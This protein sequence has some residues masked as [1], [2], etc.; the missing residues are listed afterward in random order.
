MS[1][2]FTGELSEIKARVQPVEKITH[3]HSAQ[4]RYRQY[5]R[6]SFIFIK[7]YKRFNYSLRGK[8]SYM[9]AEQTIRHN[10]HGTLFTLLYVVGHSISTQF[11]QLATKPWLCSHLIILVFCIIIILLL[12]VLSLLYQLYI[13]LFS[14]CKYVQTCFTLKNI[15]YTY[16]AEYIICHSEEKTHF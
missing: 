14:H 9:T 8:A 5:Q 16:I 3:S 10:T 11:L 15:I 4:G 2:T 6:F 7:R 13:T 12:N 1:I